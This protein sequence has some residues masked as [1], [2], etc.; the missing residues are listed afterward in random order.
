MSHDDHRHDAT[1]GAQRRALRISLVLNGG[2]LA[3][4]L[5]GGLVSGSLALLSDATHMAADVAG[6]VV[7]LTAAALATRPANAR[8]T[9]G[10]QRAEV[11]GALA[12]AAGLLVVT[13]WLAFEAVQRLGRPEPIDAAP[14][15]V[16]GVLGLAVNLVSAVLLSRAAGTSLNMR[17]AFL[18]M[19]GDA[20]G[21]AAVIVAAIAAGVFAFDRADPIASLVI[22]ALVLVSAWRLLHAAA[23]VLLEATPEGLD[24]AAVEAFLRADP[25]IDDV[26][27]LH[28]WNLASDTTALTGH[29]VLAREA[30]LHE[31]QLVGDRVK[32]ELA[33]RYGI[34]HATLELECHDCTEPP[35]GTRP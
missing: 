6:L 22:D 25:D 34:G 16:I 31:A 12:N 8:H 23:R 17:G 2:F 30:D 1:P 7:A 20:A 29:L 3:A 18:H 15:L 28:A 14:V 13:S 9:Y 32:V 10:L 19:V 4:E 5:I 33:E 11:L 21:S 24:L 26:H 35:D 27:H